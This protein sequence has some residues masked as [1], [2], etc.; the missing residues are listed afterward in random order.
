MAIVNFK[1][2]IENVSIKLPASKSIYNRLLILKYLYN[3]KFELKNP[4][5]TD[6]SILLTRLLNSEKTYLN[7]KNAGTVIRFLTAYFAA[8]GE[9][10]TLFCSVRMK[11]RPIGELVNALRELGADIEYLKNEGFPPIKINGNKKLH[12]KQVEIKANESSQ[13]LSALLMI[14]PALP[15]G[16]N[17]KV[18]DKIMSKPYIDMTLTLMKQNGF[19]IFQKGEIIEVS[20][21]KPEN[22]KA[23]TI[24][25]EPD[26]SAAVFWVE[27]VF[28]AKNLK[29]VLKNQNL[30]SIQGDSVIVQLALHFGILVRK[31][32]KNIIIS[33]SKKN[34]DIKTDWDFKNYPDL[35]P[36]L[37]VMLAA[38]KTKATVRG[39][40]TLKIKESDR[41]NALKNE[42][43]K[44]NVIFTEENGYWTLDATKFKVK[45]Y[46]AFK[47]YYDHRIAMA[48]APL[49]IFNKIVI[50]TGKVCKK[51]YPDYWKHLEKAGFEII[52]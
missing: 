10:K 19:E 8:K 32:G 50:S 9:S 30:N 29:V 47:N 18:P 5:N 16:L 15:N 38:S 42:L 39:I 28:F 14:G 17:I 1:N 48:L 36:A 3:L 45:K 44:C 11:K 4:S 51:S 7:C 31:S 41:S 13:F 12:S 46:T 6:D 34:A 27:I 20:K 26:W 52:N 37:I 25:T 33:K 24:V 49:A 40:E 2:N 43:K 22:S 35:A 21:F 23:T